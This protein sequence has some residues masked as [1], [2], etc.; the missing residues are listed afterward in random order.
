MNSNQR[1]N[2]SHACP[3]C[4]RPKEQCICARVNPVDNRTSVL[5]LQYPREQY[6][7]LNSAKLSSMVLSNCIL[8]VGLSWPNLNAALRKSTERTQ[9]GVLYL[10]SGAV[11][12]EAVQILDRKKQPV[13]PRPDIRGI[14]VL[15]G[16][17]KQAKGLWWRNPWLLK[18]NRIVLNPAKSSLRNQT[19]R[20]A[21]STAE[22]IAAALEAFGEEP[23]VYQSLAA[24]YQTL[25]V[26][27]KL[28]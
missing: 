11:S 3:S 9:W 1:I 18:L 22:A 13:R 10:G 7:L 24:Q 21:L 12:D 26:E 20:E 25:I 23:Q 27:P 4:L 19:K 17:W 28:L 8:R 15:D 14:V 2:K 16:S 5:I 6:K